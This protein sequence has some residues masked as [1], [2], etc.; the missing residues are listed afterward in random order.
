MFSPGRLRIDGF[1]TP[2]L[3]TIDTNAI[4]LHTKTPDT[5]TY[6]LRY[7]VLVPRCCEGGEG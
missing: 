3:S 6:G 2:A 1:R 7:R 4:G 5:Y